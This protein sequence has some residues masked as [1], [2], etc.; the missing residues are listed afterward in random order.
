MAT[1]PLTAALDIMRRLPPHLTA[2]SIN[3]VLDAAGDDCEVHQSSRTCDRTDTSL[4]W[5][6]EFLS[7]VDSPLLVGNDPINQTPFLLCDYNRDGDSYR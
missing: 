5:M 7:A 1:T 6:E 3:D 4:Q 2:D